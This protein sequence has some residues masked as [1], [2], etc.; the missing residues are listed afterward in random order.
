MN[1][2]ITGGSGF[3]GREV[4]R[5]LLAAGHHVRALVRHADR[6]KDFH[7]VDKIVGDTT[8]PDTLKDQLAD[9]DAVIHL[10]GIIREIPSKGVTFDKLHTLST[11]HVVAAAQEQGVKRYLQMSANGTRIKATTK[12]H[13]TKWLAEEEVRNSGLDWTIFR[14]SLI[15][16]PHD[17]FIRML[18]RMIRLLPVVPVFGDGR[19]RLQPVHVQ[20]VAASFVAALTKVDSIGKTYHCC[21]PDIYSYDE[22]LDAIA[23]ALGR[24]SG[25]CKLHQ[26]LWLMKPV[27]SAFDSLS[28]FPITRD[29]LQMLVEGNTCDSD[30]WPADFGL[31]LTPLADSI[32][33]YLR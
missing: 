1:V 23:A 14:P 20:D 12:Y 2:F 17:E 22:L 32:G 3:V 29:Q 5:Q 11:G 15:F 25:V 30:E 10:V 6:L 21:G 7:Q 16:G 18:A 33:A 24:K 13:K 8:R 9:C 27:I 4:I 26:P 31:K 28:V 19:Y